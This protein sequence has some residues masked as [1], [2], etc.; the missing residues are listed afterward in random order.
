[1]KTFIG[2]KVIKAE[3]MDL[4]TFNSMYN[5][6]IPSPKH[7]SKAGYHVIYPDNYHSWSPK[8]VFEE[9]YREISADELNF[10]N[11]G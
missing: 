4:G 8:S 9:A 7:D 11:E 10:I 2:V 5:K 1:M 3:V 6:V